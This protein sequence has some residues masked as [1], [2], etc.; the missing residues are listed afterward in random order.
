MVWRGPP[1]PPSG[2]ALGV[3]SVVCERACVSV[4]CFWRESSEMSQHTQCIYKSTWDWQLIS[5]MYL[6]VFMCVHQ[7]I[8][9]LER[10]HAEL[11]FINCAWMSGHQ[12]RSWPGEGSRD[13][14]PPPLS[15]PVGS[16][17]DVKLRWDFYV[18]GGGGGG[19]D[20]RWW[21]TRPHPPWTFKPAYAA[22]GHPQKFQLGCPT[23]PKS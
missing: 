5:S 3:L 10:T 7:R 18:Y 8:R 2:S 15:C 13:P 22:A 1:V 23:P 17:R 16:M 20:S 11:A 19:L 12:R 9:R 4:V 21:R 14:D 6:R